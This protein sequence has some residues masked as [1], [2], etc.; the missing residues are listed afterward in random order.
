CLEGNRQGGCRGG[1]EK[2]TT[3][4]RG[5][6]RSRRGCRKSPTP[7]VVGD[8]ETSQLASHRRET[9]REGRYRKG[10]ANSPAGGR[11]H[12]ERSEAGY[13]QCKSR[14]REGSKPI[15]QVL[16][17]PFLPKRANSRSLQK[18]C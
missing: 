16:G 11:R 14:H 1:I 5:S 9:R 2:G 6:S 8:H 17:E 3:S 7:Y 10:C 13:D 4:S 18:I 15:I 12:G